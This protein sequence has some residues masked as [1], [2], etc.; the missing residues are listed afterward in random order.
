MEH[1]YRRKPLYATMAL[2]LV[3]IAAIALARSGE[4]KP[5]PPTSL[6]ASYMDSTSAAG[7]SFANRDD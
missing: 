2:A 5:A 1:P 6:F 7:R 4:Q 3:T